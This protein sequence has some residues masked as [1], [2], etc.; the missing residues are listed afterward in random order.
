MTCAIVETGL[1]S[2]VVNIS[3]ALFAS[4]P[5]LTGAQEIADEVG[6]CGIVG[7]PN[8]SLTRLNS[9]T[10][11]GLNSGTLGNYDISQQ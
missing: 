6:T 10:C 11:M 3:F 5:R 7:T 1:I 2:T 4:V 9:G 8:S